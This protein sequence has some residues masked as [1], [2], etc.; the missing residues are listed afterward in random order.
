MNFNDF[1]NPGSLERALIELFALKSAVAG[2]LIFIRV[3]ARRPGMLGCFPGS[4]V[5]GRA[6]GKCRTKKRVEKRAA[7]VGSWCA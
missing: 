4:L 1:Y 6:V 5:F 3:T 7:S 2:T